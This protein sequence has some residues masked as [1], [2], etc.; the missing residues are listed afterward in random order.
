VESLFLQAD[1]KTTAKKLPKKK[2]DF[3]NMVNFRLKNDIFVLLLRKG[4]NLW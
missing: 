4:G 2:R 1:I 3:G